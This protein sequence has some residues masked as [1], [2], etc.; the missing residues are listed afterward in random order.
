MLA[1]IK[2]IISLIKNIFILKYVMLK[3][4][5]FF[6]FLKV[7]TISLDFI[8][9]GLKILTEI[10]QLIAAIGK[11]IFSVLFFCFSLVFLKF[12]KIIVAF[13]KIRAERS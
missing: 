12:A 10:I 9:K 1:K 3:N 5:V 2:K 7:K 4:F 6:T 11:I 8:K 13:R